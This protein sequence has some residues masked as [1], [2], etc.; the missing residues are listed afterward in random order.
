MH[1]RHAS[2]AKEVQ[3]C[4]FVR[5]PAHL[6]ANGCNDRRWINRSI[7]RWMDKSIDGWVERWIDRSIDRSIHSSIDR[8][9]DRSMCR[10]S[11]V[12]QG[13][14]SQPSCARSARSIQVV[15]VNPGRPV[16]K[17]R[18]IWARSS[19][20]ALSISLVNTGDLADPVHLLNSL[21][22]GVDAIDPSGPLC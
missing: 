22:R 7:D 21:D 4:A 16:D 10:S 11:S 12:N 8:S 18:P 17:G 1:Q 2:W 14:L 20:S 6:P 13:W 19:R 9:I 15:S 3:T 5:P